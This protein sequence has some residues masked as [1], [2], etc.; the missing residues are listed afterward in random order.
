M[1]PKFLRVLF[2]NEGVG[3]KIKTEL[4]PFED[5]NIS[6]TYPIQGGGILDNNPNIAVAYATESNPGVIQI[7]NNMTSDSTA[8]TPADMVAWVQQYVVQYVAS[9]MGNVP[10]SGGWPDYANFT[11][12]VAYCSSTGSIETIHWRAPSNGFF[13][14]NPGT[15]EGGNGTGL[16][17]M[18]SNTLTSITAPEVFYSRNPAIIGSPK[19]NKYIWRSN[20]SGTGDGDAPDPF[21]SGVIPVTAGLGLHFNG[22]SGTYVRGYFCKAL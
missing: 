7:A 12:V 13:V 9:Q 18:G 22:R 5:R 20:V 17:D 15:I 1:L 8:L 3:P 6:V 14:A 2:K 10:T 19:S 4:I 11:P 21:T 16:G